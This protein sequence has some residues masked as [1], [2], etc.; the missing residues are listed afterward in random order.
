MVPGLW[1]GHG[2]HLLLLLL[3]P[4]PWLLIFTHGLCSFSYIAHSLH[5]CRNVSSIG[6][7]FVQ[8]WIFMVPLDQFMV[9]Y[10]FFFLSIL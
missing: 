3:L 8:G 10:F 1:V 7:H 9:I 4:T 6:Y 2:L 5:L